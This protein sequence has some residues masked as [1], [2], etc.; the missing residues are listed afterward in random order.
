MQSSACTTCVAHNLC[1]SSESKEKIIDV[2]T[3]DAAS[4]KMEEQVVLVGN[5]KMGMNAVLWAYLVPLVWL[6]F[7]LV[8]A[9]RMTSDEPLA[10]LCAL[11]ALALYYGVLYIN[12]GRLARKFSFTIKHIK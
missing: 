9:V 2:F 6:V 7:V 4:F 5:L 12:R 1:N 8:I 11:G 3:D 10:A